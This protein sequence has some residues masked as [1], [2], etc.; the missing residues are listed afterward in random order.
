MKQFATDYWKRYFR[1][2]NPEC[3]EC[4]REFLERKEELQDYSGLL[5][6]EGTP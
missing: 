4:G 3:A 5:K 6:P 2:K 1:C